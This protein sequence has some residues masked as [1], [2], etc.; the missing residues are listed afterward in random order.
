[1]KQDLYR[2]V[3]NGYKSGKGEYYI[4][5]NFANLF[6]ITPEKAKE[7]FADS[8]KTLKENFSLDQA[9]Q[10]QKVIEK[11]GASCVVENMKFDLG[12]LSLE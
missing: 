3:L 10:Y 12:G 1:M 6:K 9:E 7:F 2:V 5:K 4:E 8:P 11:T